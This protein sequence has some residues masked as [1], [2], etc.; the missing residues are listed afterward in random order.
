MLLCGS[1]RL[2]YPLLALLV[3]AL[4]SF[5]SGRVQGRLAWIVVGG[6]YALSTVI[7]A[8][9]WLFVAGPETLYTHLRISRDG[10]VAATVV[11]RR[12]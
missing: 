1:R 3:H 8:P 9:L 12:R 2:P 4:V 6:A 7:Q 11:C 5:P 10:S